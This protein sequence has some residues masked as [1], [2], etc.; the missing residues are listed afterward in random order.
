M[1]IPSWFQDMDGDASWNVYFQHFKA[2]NAPKEKTGNADADA[3][4]SQPKSKEE[5]EREREAVLPT[6]SLPLP[7]HCGLTVQTL[8]PDC[9]NTAVS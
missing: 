2:W 4:R 1:Q 9:P 7:K 3:D 8:R 5:A 6:V